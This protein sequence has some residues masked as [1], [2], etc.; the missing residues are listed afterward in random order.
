MLDEDVAGSYHAVLGPQYEEGK[1]EVVTAAECARK[2]IRVVVEAPKTHGGA[3]FRMTVSNGSDRELSEVVFPDLRLDAKGVGSG[4]TT[5]VGP[6]WWQ[7]FECLSEGEHI[8]WNY[9]VHGSMQWVDY[10]DE[11]SGVYVGVH[12]PTPYIKLFTIGK[13]DRRPWVRVRFTDIHLMPV[14]TEMEWNTTGA[15][16]TESYGS[17]KCVVDFAVMCPGCR[18]WREMFIRRLEHVARAYRVDGSFVDQVCGCWSYPCYSNE[19]DHSRPNESW[20]G[21]LTLLK[22]LRTRL[23][24]INPEFSMST[25]GVCDILGQYF[26]IQQGHNDWDTQVGAK[27]IPMPELYGYTFPWYTVNTGYASHNNY[28]FLKLAHAVGSGLDVCAIEPE[29]LEE[30]FLRYLKL[31]MAWRK[32]YVEVLRRGEF[33][34][35]LES[36]NPHYLAHAFEKDGRLVVTAAWVPYKCDPDRPETVTLNLG[37]RAVK[38]AKLLTEDGEREVSVGVDG[39]DSIVHVPLSEIAVLEVA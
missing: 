20:S 4:F 10:C 21:Y 29:K 38:S 17:E 31:I 39:R 30:R 3:E 25:E 22:E 28:Y 2:G 14:N 6:G 8:N 18:E 37:S 16:A 7:P 27:S 15:A 12:D 36:D 11:C 9:P 1:R 23:R 35:A 34:G 24:A 26:D 33:V 19:H 13:R 5:P 32:R